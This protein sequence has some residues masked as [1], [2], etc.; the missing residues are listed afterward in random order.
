[1]AVFAIPLAWLQLKRERVRLLI[2]LAGIG[3]AVILMFMQL[4]FRDAL[5]ASAVRLHLAFKTDVV[6]VSP[7]S[8]AIIAMQSFPRRRLYQTLGFA[9]V[10]SVSPVYLDFALWKNPETLGTRGI[11]VVG[12]NP[13]VDVLDAPGLQESR[14]QMKLADTVLF[15]RDSRAEFGPITTWLEQGRT[16]RTEVGTRRIQVG[17]LIQLGASFG[18]DG[19]IVTSDLNF[20]RLFPNRDPGQIDVGLIQLEPGAD[21]E[22]VIANLRA[23]LPNDVTVFSKQDFVDFEQDYWRSSTAIG[24]IFT[25]GTLMGF[26]VG[27][28]I[29]YQILYTDVSDHLAEYA[30]LKAMGYTNFYLLTIV[31]QEAVILSFLGYIPGFFL[32]IGL[33]HLTRNATALP[34]SMTLD[35]SI[36]VLAL[37]LI[38]C[39][40]SGAIAVRKV[41]DADPADIF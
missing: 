23:S 40:I 6:L 33:Y 18:A 2:A 29:V 13:S 16:V 22:R 12:L 38:M 36:L 9:G 24:F 37:T 41:Q 34:V 17:G 8:T 10:Q 27:T 15:D 32:C 7:Q 35:R 11:L 5:Y 26:I 19:N 1:M 21:L 4:G 30:T 14:Q 39:V 25:L 31:F 20:L 3:F 28:V